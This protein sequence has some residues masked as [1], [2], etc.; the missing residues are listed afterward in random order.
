MQLPIFLHR[1]YT[2]NTNEYQLKLPLNI[3]AII[4]AD[5][6]VRLLSQF[7]EGMDLTDLYST[8]ERIRE[9]S[10]SPRTLLKIVL[11]SYMNGDYSSRSMEQNCKRDIN[12]MYLLEGAKAPHHATF[13]R[14]RSI[15]FAP[16]SKRILAEMTNKLYDLGEISGE[17]IF[18]D[19]TKIEASANK[20]TFVWKKA[21]TKN[22]V[23]LLLKLA[24][25]IAECEQLYDIQICY[26][27]TVQMR[28][29]KRLRKKLYALKESEH[30]VFVHGIGKR[31]SPLQKSIET[32]EEYLKRLK[33]Y[34]QKLHICGERNSYS[35]TD[36]DAT[37]MRMKEDAMGNGQL[38][39]AYNLQHGVDAEYITW[40]TIGPQPTDTTTLIPF[41][42]E[43]ERYLAFKYKKIVAD[44][45]YESEEN[46]LFLERNG[47]VAFIKPANYEIS[48]TR[49]YK[50]DIGKIENMDYVEGKDVYICKN[51]KELSLDCIRHS[52]SKTGYVSDKHIYKCKDCSGCPYKKECIKG[53]NCK[54][55]LEERNKVLQVAKK[56]IKQRQ[57]DLARITSEEGIQLRV[58]RSIQAEGSF[59]DLKQDMQFR[60]YL[61]KGSSNVLAESTLLAMARNINKLHNKIQNG[62][63]G[64][65]LFQVKSA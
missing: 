43:T 13:A 8:Y 54:T 35:K 50:N 51:G 33:E 34:T 11:Y 18:I 37:F 5:D 1:D 19:G 30:L 23:K 53:N 63:T 41:L 29:V 17:S 6:S 32:L 62:K 24:D 25:F 15:H 48:K 44:A 2:K 45:G 9:N 42:K 58:N 22:L 38:K 46:Y 20:Y 26:S 28:H 60:R 64:M 14:F 21:V 52:K 56:F 31:K 4:P 36:H 57:E 40:L 47:Q 10:V 39:P 12:F 27:K 59:G 65:H 49:K 16:C 7:V 3:E 55:P 61:S